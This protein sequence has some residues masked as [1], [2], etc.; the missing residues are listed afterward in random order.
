[1]QS[2]QM[3]QRRSSRIQARRNRQVS[4]LLRSAESDNAHTH[5]EHGLSLYQPQEKQQFGQQ[6]PKDSAVVYTKNEKY[7]VSRLPALPNILKLKDDLSFSGGIDSSTDAALLLTSTF[8]YV[9]RYTSPDHLPATIS[10]PINNPSDVLPLGALVSPSAGSTEPGLVLVHPLT[11]KV[12]YYEAVGGA[13]A[14]GLLHR[15]KGVESIIGL[16]QGEILEHIQNIEPVGIIVATSSGRFVLI[17]L[18]DAAGR[19]GISCTVMRGSGSGLWSNLKGVLNLG[20]TRRDVTAI[21]PGKLLGRGERM[22]ITIN[23]RGAVTTWQCSR[24]GNYSLLFEMDLRPQLIQSIIEVYPQSEKT[25]TVHDIE[26]LPGDDKS[27]LILSSFIYDE[28]GKNDQIYYVLFTVYLD[29]EDFRIIST[30]RI[31]C[32]SVKSTRTPKLL[33]P[34][35]GNTS[36]IVL[37][38]AVIMVDT[39]FQRSTISNFKWEDVVEF[40]SEIDIFTT[41]Y[42]DLVT[43]NQQVTRHSGIILLTRGAG[44]IRVERLEDENEG[45]AVTSNTEVIKSKLRQAVYFGNI[46]ETP[47]SFEASGEVGYNVDHIETAIDEVSDEIIIGKSEYY[48]YIEDVSENLNVRCQALSRLLEHLSPIFSSL[49]VKSRLNT[50]WK[51]EKCEAAQKIYGLYATSQID[52]H[53][54]SSAI[55]DFEEKQSIEQWFSSEVVRIGELAIAI[56]NKSLL[57]ARKA[58]NNKSLMI[59]HVKEAN[60]TLLTLLARSA[61]F[62]RS[63][64]MKEVFKLADSASSLNA[65]PWTSSW[66]ILT[67]LGKLYDITKAICGELWERTGKSDDNSEAEYSEMVSQL[68]LLAECL[69]RAYVERIEYCSID[70]RLHEQREKLKAMY[71]EQRASWIKPLLKF[72]HSEKAFQLA[73]HYNDFRS[74]AEMC[75]EE[76]VRLEGLNQADSEIE[77]AQESLAS[78]IKSYFDSHGYEFAA[79]LYQYYIDAGLVSLL[80]IEF[81][82]YNQ[83]LE[84]FF[85]SG[86]YDRVAWI[87]DIQVNDFASAGKKLERVVDELDDSLSNKRLQLSIAKLCLISAKNTGGSTDKDIE[88]VNDRL[89]EIEDAEI[90]EQEQHMQE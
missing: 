58:S 62:I 29:Q 20:S 7:C 8:A 63:H 15:K 34:Q 86:K 39:L 74:L 23:V 33:L 52:S 37:S 40:R 45:A 72:G 5:H 13:I 57:A 16:Y 9:W 4:G 53:I 79:V 55:S 47:L 88:N 83:H 49:S 24:S 19:P 46:E 85:S 48:K 78:R 68:V 11:G 27:G 12:L 89:I 54:L 84:K 3:A 32:Y 25:F 60:I 38:N 41:G 17:S 26:M 87:H 22:V 67:T 82:S 70:E 36:F 71:N 61:Y 64:F 43:Q 73:E 80:F 44:V 28:N 50:M 21:K 14:E 30:H 56:G 59:R 31:T 90:A 1:M 75:R 18:H 65:V 76:K 42:E 69:C 2:T 51:L 81:P 35:P 66:E 6:R 10:F 77:A